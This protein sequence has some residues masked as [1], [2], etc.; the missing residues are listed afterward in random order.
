MT[1][2][3]RRGRRNTLCVISVT[4]VTTLI[5]LLVIPISTSVPSDGALPANQTPQELLA[6]ITESPVTDAPRSTQ[7]ELLSLFRMRVFV[8]TYNRPD[9]LATILKSLADANYTGSPFPIDL[10]VSMDYRS[11]ADNPDEI[12]KQNQTLRQLESFNWKHG[13]FTLRRRIA[14]SGLRTSIMEAWYP[15]H[16]W[17]IAAFFED[18]IE[19]SPWWFQWMLGGLRAYGIP[20]DGHPRAAAALKVLQDSGYTTAGAKERLEML[21]MLHKSVPCVLPT[22]MAGISL[23]RSDK[24]QLSERIIDKDLESGGLGPFVLQQPC[25]WGA[26]YFPQQWRA[27]RR[28]FEFDDI[29][30]GDV[31]DPRDPAVRPGSNQ[32]DYLSSW[33]KYLIRFMYWQGLYM[34]YPHLPSRY[35]LSTTHLLPGTHHT[36]PAKWFDLPL[37]PAKLSSSLAEHVWNF[38]KLGTLRVFD[39]IFR[40]VEAISLLPNYERTP[41]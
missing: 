24:D 39:I 32:W 15:T 28:W 5:V 34:I 25:S 13:T 4:L 20:E 35:V 6:A 16:D 37:L 38:P 11:K 31:K 3:G 8:F 2:K 22:H 41:S 7:D 9:G 18:D 10:D 26:V 40:P 23:Y 33:K 1:L 21:P 29:G 12:R 36:P 19:V 27:F 30:N 14:N 17:E